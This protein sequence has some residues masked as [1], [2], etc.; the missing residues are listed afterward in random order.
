MTG[1]VPHGC[2]R[3][4]PFWDPYPYCGMPIHA[5]IIAQLFYP[6]TWIAILLG[7]LSGVLNLFYWIEWLDPL[8]MILAGVF[9]FLLLREFDASPPAALLGGTVCILKLAR[10]ITLRWVALLA[11]SVALAILSGFP[12]AV[13][14][15]NPDP[16]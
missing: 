9:A 4:P 12:A 13:G 1:A 11:I 16:E 8:H 2:H 15:N 5:D 6:F 10:A 14:F 7:N 3:V